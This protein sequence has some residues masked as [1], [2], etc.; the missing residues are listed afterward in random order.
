M[1]VV[2]CIRKGGVWAPAWFQEKTTPAGTDNQFTP[3][4]KRGIF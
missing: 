2:V 1:M 3:E 4:A